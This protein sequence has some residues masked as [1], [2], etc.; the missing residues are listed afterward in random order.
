MLESMLDKLELVEELDDEDDEKVL[1][2]VPVLLT[3]MLEQLPMLTV[4][5][6]VI[7]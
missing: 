2:Q 6:P 5:Q 4:F 1:R 3:E 7:S